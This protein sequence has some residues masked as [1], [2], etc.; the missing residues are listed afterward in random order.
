MRPRN[1]DHAA[2]RGRLDVYWAEGRLSSRRS[3][4]KSVQRPATRRPP[5]V[6]ASLGMG[7]EPLG[8]RVRT[9][10]QPGP[11]LALVDVSATSPLVVPVHTC[12]GM[13]SLRC[14]RL[15]SGERVGIAFTA[16]ASLTRVMGAGQPWIHMSAEAMRDM[17]APLGVTRIQVDPGVI[18]AGRP[19]S[20]P[21]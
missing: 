7:R 8:L 20:V 14:G 4:A 13:V 16:E 19:V 21:A 15:P 3:T 9:P 12:S 11:G 1:S 5:L 17:L 18:T 2:R 10:A 6:S